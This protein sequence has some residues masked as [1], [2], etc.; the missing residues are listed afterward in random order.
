MNEYLE[1]LNKMNY[2]FTA[3]KSF[4]DCK[5]GFKLGYLD[6]VS[7]V[8][9]AFSD[10]GIAVH[11]VLEA[12]FSGYVEEKDLANF[13]LITFDR[14]VTNDF[15]PTNGD[16]DM[17]QYYKNVGFDFF[18]QFSFD[19]ERYEVKRAEGALFWQEGNFKLNARPDLLLYDKQTGETILL[20]Y[21]TAKLKTT[22]KEKEEQMEQLGH[23]MRLYCRGLEQKLGIKVDKAHVW[24][25]RRNKLVEIDINKGDIENTLR[26]LNNTR[27]EMQEETEWAPN[28]TEKQA[29]F[30]NYICGVREHCEFKKLMP[31]AEE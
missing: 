18:A 16:F 24:F 10:F 11:K 22:P 29:F 28:N 2:S 23:Q 25:V 20:D 21:K 6:K 7:R 9:N 14:I 30:C 26:W 13:F 3:M 4:N 5:Y 1:K 12:Y 27:K 31:E 8:N 17:R 15:P 19:K